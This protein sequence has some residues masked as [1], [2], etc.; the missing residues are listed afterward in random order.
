MN[1][2]EQRIAIA[3]Y[4]GTPFPS[5]TL[6]EEYVNHPYWNDG[7]WTT[8]I[9]FQG[10]LEEYDTSGRQSEVT[11]ELIREIYAARFLPNYCNDL[12]AMHEAEKFLSAVPPKP[13]EKSDIARY[14]EILCVVTLMKG[15]PITATASNRAE[16]FLKTIG[17]WEE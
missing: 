9:R 1:Q 8:K 17:K 10:V 5:Y 6:R 15:G 16:A 11:V 7:F 12:N 4:C 3:E 14:R 2:T 13:E